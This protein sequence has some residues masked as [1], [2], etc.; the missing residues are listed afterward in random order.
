MSQL[1]GDKLIA[2]FP[3]LGWWDQNRDLRTE[4]MNFS[5]VVTVCGPGVYA[6]ISPRLAVPAAIVQV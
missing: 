6:A 2:V 1:A 5:L 4:A 3:V